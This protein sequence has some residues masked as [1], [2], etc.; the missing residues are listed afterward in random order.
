MVD[1][2]VQ[3][4]GYLLAESWADMLVGLME[5]HSAVLLGS[6]TV[7]CLAMSMVGWMEPLKVV[8]REYSLVDWKD[9][10]SAGSMGSATAV[11]LEILFRLIR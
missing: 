7:A 8:M 4:M 10:G 2:T 9:F 1:R 5:I 3:L 11:L 6:T